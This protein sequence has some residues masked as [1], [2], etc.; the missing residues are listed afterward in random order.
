M[1]D[2][3]EERL[4]AAREKRA[5]LARA[6]ADRDAEKAKLAELEAEERRAADEE[7]IAKAEDEHGELNKRI[8][9][10]YTDMGVVIVR[11]PNV[12]AFNAFVE[13]K[14]PTHADLYNLAS[15]CVVHPDPSRFEA[16]LAEQPFVLVRA[17]DAVAWL[18]G[19]RKEEIEGK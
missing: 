12:A 3:I 17:A 18:A 13:K 6:R 1:G 19:V 11:R 4:K 16:M 7:A 8:R 15:P 5:N 10:V 2:D 9:P 14:S